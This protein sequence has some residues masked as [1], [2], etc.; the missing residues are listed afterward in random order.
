MGRRSAL[1]PEQWATVQHRHI[2]DGESLRNLAKE[3]GVNESSLRR[4]IGPKVVEA[5]E[6]EDLRELAA[7]KA[8]VDGEAMVVNSEIE[9]LPIAK[10]M[11][12]SNLARKLGAISTHVASSSEYMSAVAHRAS[13]MVHDLMQRVDDADPSK[14]IEVLKQISALIGLSNNAAIQPMGLLKANQET[15]D[16]INSGAEGNGHRPAAPVYQIVKG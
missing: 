2:V 10:Q 3:Y 4:K 16:A 13:G 7:R 8:R 11:I 1:T 15:I 6:T 9:S 5:G 14:S 12:V